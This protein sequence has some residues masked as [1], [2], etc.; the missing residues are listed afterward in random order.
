MAVLTCLA[1]PGRFKLTDGANTI[2]RYQHNT[3]AVALN[4]ISD[5][6]AVIE[7]NHEDELYT[8]K[9]LGVRVVVHWL[10]QCAGCGA[11]SVR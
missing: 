9:D 8:V 3:V 1:K 10:A 6:H 11:D 7:I 5:E 2:G 4:S